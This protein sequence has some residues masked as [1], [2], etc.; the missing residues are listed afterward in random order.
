M[1]GDVAQNLAITREAWPTR[2][3][4]E[5]NLPRT[6]WTRRSWPRPIAPSQR[7]IRTSKILLIVRGGDIVYE[8]YSGS[9]GPT[10]R[11]I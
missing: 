10:S 5:A 9:T 2:G 4:P 3:W 8:R 1:T 6:A 11:T 7:S